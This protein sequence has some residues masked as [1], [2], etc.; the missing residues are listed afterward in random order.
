MLD[1]S[2][3]E[4]ETLRLS[5]LGHDIVGRGI[6]IYFCSWLEGVFTGEATGNFLFFLREHGKG[7]HSLR[8]LNRSPS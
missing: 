8:V 4:R 1:V 7:T 2:E 3:A 5:L 6:I